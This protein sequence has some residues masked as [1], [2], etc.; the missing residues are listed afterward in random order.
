MW[1][2]RQWMATLVFGFVCVGA[3][4]LGSAGQKVVLGATVPVGQRL[5]FQHVDHREWSRLLGAYV[6]RQGRVDYARWQKNANDERALDNYLRELSRAD[7]SRQAAREAKLAYWIN[8]YNA[9]T[10]KGILREYPT[11]SIRQHTAKLYGYNIWHDLLLIVGN[12]KI[13]LNDIEHEVLRKHGDF[14]IHFAIVCASHS[15]PRLLNAAY[16]VPQIE[17][18]LETNTRVF[19]RNSENY[20]YADGTFYLSSILK[21]YAKDFGST[22]A[23]QLQAIASYLPNRKAQQLASQGR[24]KIA[25]LR[26]DWSLNDQ[27]TSRAKD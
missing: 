5:S 11:T 7:P 2:S 10:I 16:T 8:A 17:Q 24:G 27:A 9:V 23:A 22:P 3:A 20:R 19:F 6:D 18:Q 14:R 1:K 25:Y 15:C 12:E 26:Y 4:S 21:W 13:S